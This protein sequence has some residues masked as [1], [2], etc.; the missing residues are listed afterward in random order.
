VLFGVDQHLLHAP[1]TSVLGRVDVGVPD[2]SRLGIETDA[3][4][5]DAVVLE[6]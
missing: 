4:V 2:V 3:F 5:V 1:R 6:C